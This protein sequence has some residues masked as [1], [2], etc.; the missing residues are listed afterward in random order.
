MLLG[1][2][3]TEFEC[4]HPHAGGDDCA[5]FRVPEEWIH[6]A[7][8]SAGTG[9]G[10]IEAFPAKVLAPLPR[11]ALAVD[12]AMRAREAGE[13][14]DVDGLAAAVV[15][16]VMDGWNRARASREPSKA[17]HERVRAAVD[18]IEARSEEALPLA[19]L[20][21]LVDASPFHLAHAFR[22]IT[23]TTPHRYL[24]GARLRRAAALLLDT[25]RPVTDIAY[26][27]GFGDLSNFV[28]TFRREL[29]CS[30]RRYRA[31]GPPL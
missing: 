28:R 23:G 18:L 26:G 19:E 10:S 6:E 21:D 7:A 3:G 1:R 5:A 31:S 12:R 14:I 8:R 15:G 2:P 29:G 22:A 30:P 13:E 17:D 9:A 27:V 20:A 24:V 4:G 11:V 16:A 25:D